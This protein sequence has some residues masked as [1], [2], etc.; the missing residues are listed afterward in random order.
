MGKYKR[1]ATKEPPD[2]RPMIEDYM[3]EFVGK[4]P[5]TTR[6]KLM[7]MLEDV[8]GEYAGLPRSREAKNALERATPEVLDEMI[9]DGRIVVYCGG[10][11]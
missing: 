9:R 3:L 2:L 8:F 10:L 6:D 1:S 11:Y 4:V 7:R 5:G